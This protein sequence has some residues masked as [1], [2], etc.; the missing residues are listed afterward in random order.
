MTTVVPVDDAADPRLEELVGLTDAEARRTTEAELGCFV[1]E[2]LLVLDALVRSP[3]PIRSVLASEAKLDRVLAV[4]DGVDAEVFVGSQALLEEVTGFA[5]HRG[6]VASAGRLPL[7]EPEYLVSRE[8]PVLV[9]EGVNDH[10]NL[11]AL[12][13]NAAAFGVGAVLLDPTTADPL[14]RRA[15]RVSLGHVL[16]VPWTRTG[17]LLDG[18]SALRAA[19]LTTV[20][21]TPSGDTDVRE[22]RDVGRI[23]WL[24]GAEGAGLTPE[25]LAA[26]DVRARIPMTAGVDSLNV[27]TA[28]AVA[29]ALTAP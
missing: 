7:T 19:H 23:A 29:L 13:R 1:A 26:A 9:V 14:Y 8:G 6:V 15:V 28:A 18:L 2:G 10:E 11:G 20:A 5:I 17:P 12:F 22:L 16:H 21:L 27:A 24:L 4:L 25:T 3:Y